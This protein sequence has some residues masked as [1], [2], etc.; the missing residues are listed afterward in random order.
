MTITAE[1]EKNL[2]YFKEHLDT[3]LTDVAYRHLQIAKALGE[4]AAINNK[5][6]FVHKVVVIQT[7]Q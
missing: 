7:W 5:G 1:M 4:V 2:R 3:W 6:Y